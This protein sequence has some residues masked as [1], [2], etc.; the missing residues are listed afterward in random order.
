[1]IDLRLF[2]DEDLPLCRDV[3]C[4]RVDGVPWLVAADG[5]VLVAASMNAATT[6][7]ERI[8]GWVDVASRNQMPDLVYRTFVALLRRLR[9]YRV[10]LADLRRWV[11]LAATVAERD[12]QCFGHVAVDRCLLHRVVEVLPG[13]IVEVG[14]AGSAD[15]IVMAAQAYFVTVM[16]W[17]ADLGGVGDDPFALSPYFCAA[18]AGFE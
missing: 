16:P 13:E 5:H 17:D 11:S 7:A 15:G 12:P 2:C 10:P 9:P 18:A 4:T 8:V 3:T 6:P 1:M 14:T